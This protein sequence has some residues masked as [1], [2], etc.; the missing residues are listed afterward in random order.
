MTAS[1]ETVLPQ[2]EAA[3]M[4]AWVNKDRA[5]CESILAEDLLLTSARG[6][7]PHHGD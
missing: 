6:I 4:Q 3:W 7:L 5:T 1:A 2:L